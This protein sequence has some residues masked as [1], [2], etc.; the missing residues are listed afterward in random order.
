[1]GL[2][3]G[4]NGAL[5]FAALTRFLLPAAGLLCVVAAVTVVWLVE[6]A[7]AGWVRGAVAV[8]LVAACAPFAA[9]RTIGVRGQYDEVADRARA[10]RDLAAVIDAVGGASRCQHLRAVDHRYGRCAPNGTRLAGRAPASE[11]T[12]TTAPYSGTVV[13][14]AGGGVARAPRREPGAEQVAGNAG[15][16]VFRVGRSP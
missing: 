16:K 6:A 3:V 10:E 5:G 15:W 4:M 14:V 13:A 7:P 11:V 9:P 2:V 1:M 8:G 12:R